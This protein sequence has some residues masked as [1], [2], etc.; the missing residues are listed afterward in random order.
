MKNHIRPDGSQWHVL[1][2]DQKTGRVTSRT[3][4]QGYA[5]N[6]TWSRG[7]AWGLYGFANA[8]NWTGRPEFRV[9]AYRMADRFLQGLPKD[10]VPY[11]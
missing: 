6:S 9:T 3:T 10:G 5:N 11:W 7:Q 2:Y 8:Y 4:A 1:N